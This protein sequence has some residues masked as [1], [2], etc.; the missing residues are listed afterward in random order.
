MSNSTPAQVVV[1]LPPPPKSLGLHLFLFCRLKDISHSQGDNFPKALR[2]LPA[3]LWHCPGWHG[4]LIF[5]L[6]PA[7][8]STNRFAGCSR[9][10]LGCWAC[11]SLASSPCLSQALQRLG[12][13]SPWTMGVG[14]HHTGQGQTNT[15]PT[16]S[17]FLNEHWANHHGSY[18]H[19]HLSPMSAHLWGRQRATK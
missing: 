12:C 18:F 16:Q 17:A 3:S 1:L 4:R 13:S 19:S 15:T 2:A 6:C 8:Q 10:F 14:T 7:G 9:S 5:L 11:Q